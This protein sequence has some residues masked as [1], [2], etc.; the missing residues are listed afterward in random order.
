VVGGTRTPRQR[1]KADGWLKDKGVTLYQS[2]VEDDQL[3]GE[4]EAAWASVGFLARVPSARAQQMR[5]RARTGSRARNERTR[6]PSLRFTLV[7]RPK[8]ADLARWSRCGPRRS[9]AR[10]S[11]PICLSMLLCDRIV[12]TDTDADKV[13]L[14][15]VFR[16]V[17]A[18]AFPMT[19]PRLAVWIELTWGHGDTQMVLALARITP[20]DVDGDVLLAVRFTV[21]F[22]DPRTIHG[23]HQNL[24]ALQ[25]PAPGEYRLGLRA[26][27]QVV[28]ERRIEVRRHGD[29]GA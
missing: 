25:F 6:R 9:R 27:G 15:G 17:T 1:A 10:R 24:V 18:S 11:P 5:R 2:A 13:T 28:F 14:Q 20:E 3:A 19:I 4:V 21:R 16:S 23:H 29:G 26:F 8:E 7:A 22:E 12:C